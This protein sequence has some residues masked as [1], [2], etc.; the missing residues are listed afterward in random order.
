MI[1]RP[2]ANKYREGKLQSTLKRESKGPEIFNVEEFQD[3]ALG[4]ILLRL[5]DLPEVLT[6]LLD[7]IS[8]VS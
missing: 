3:N 5:A 6:V 4:C 1:P 2:I 8:L 7:C